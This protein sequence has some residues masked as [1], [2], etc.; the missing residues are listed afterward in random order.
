M[1]WAFLCLTLI[2]Y[3]CAKLHANSN[4]YRLPFGHACP[5]LPSENECH[6]FAGMFKTNLTQSTIYEPFDLHVDHTKLC[7]ENNFAD[8]LIHYYL[9]ETRLGETTAMNCFNWYTKNTGICRYYNGSNSGINNYSTYASCMADGLADNMVNKDGWV[10]TLPYL[11]TEGKTIHLFIHTGTEDGIK[12]TRCYPC[13]GVDS[14]GTH[15]S[16]TA[17]NIVAYEIKIIKKDC[18][19]KPSTKEFHWG[20]IAKFNQSEVQVV[21]KHT[22]KTSSIY[23]AGQKTNTPC[24]EDNCEVGKDLHKIRVELGDLQNDNIHNFQFQLKPSVNMKT[25]LEDF[26]NPATTTNDKFFKKE[27]AYD[28]ALFTFVYDTVSNGLE[29]RPNEIHYS[30]EEAK[31]A[32]NKDSA[33]CLGVTHR[34]IDGVDF[35]FRHTGVA[36]T[37]LDNHQQNYEENIYYQLQNKPFFIRFGASQYGLQDLEKL[38]NSF[39]SCF[40]YGNYV[41]NNDANWDNEGSVLG[42]YFAVFVKEFDV[43]RLYPKTYGGVSSIQFQT[44]PITE[45]QFQ[46]YYYSNF[47]YDQCLDYALVRNKTF[48]DTMLCDGKYCEFSLEMITYDNSYG[49]LNILSYEECFFAYEYYKNGGFTYNFGG[50]VNASMDVPRGCYVDASTVYHNPSEHSTYSCSNTYR[51]LQKLIARPICNKEYE[52]VFV[53]D[54]VMP[55]VEETL[56]EKECSDFFYRTVYGTPYVHS[57]NGYSIVEE[58]TKPTGCIL[59]GRYFEYN[60]VTSTTPCSSGY[61]CFIK[62]EKRNQVNYQVVAVLSG[63]NDN[64]LTVDECRKYA[65]EVK[66]VNFFIYNYATCQQVVGYQDK[67]MFD[68]TCMTQELHAEPF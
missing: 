24:T 50:T 33:S 62:R 52:I 29:Y 8:K 16:F 42:N 31:D 55:T 18:I 7:F 45:E 6:H 32:C 53:K 21:C 2:Q 59:D 67:W 10:T 36:S 46:A 48:E 54:G 30:M 58:N 14:E 23:Q 12:F 65:L 3:T 68:T 28:K 41:T 15:P 37:D 1:L 64:T 51:C 47:S 66:A 56:S 20:D 19:Y 25:F 26:Q 57:F 13:S 43:H 38:C 40:A 17:E 22:K 61:P 60:S 34:Q 5:N 49:A 35:Y 63:Y 27:A 11:N 9:D 39:S 44:E 4:L